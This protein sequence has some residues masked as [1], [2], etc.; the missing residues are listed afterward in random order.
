MATKSTT[1]IATVLGFPEFPGFVSSPP[2][3][4][5]KLTWSGSSEQ[6]TWFGSQPA[7]GGPPYQI[8]GA[9]FDY[10]GS[11]EIDSLGN[12]ISLYTK[13]LFEM[14]SATNDQFVTS[15]VADP[16]G[17]VD[18]Y[19]AP[20]WRGPTGHLK[21]QDPGVPYS[22]VRSTAVGKGDLAILDS[23]HFWGSKPVP[24]TPIPTTNF[25]ASSN[26]D[27][28]CS[29]TGGSQSNGVLLALFEPVPPGTGVPINGATYG[30]LWFFGSVVWI[31]DYTAT[32]SEEYTD[33]EALTHAKTF[34]GNGATAQNFVRTTG[35]TSTFTNVVYTLTLTSLIV[36]QAYVVSVDLW[37]TGTGVTTTKQ[38]G[39]TA[40][41]TTQQITDVIPTP[42][43]QHLVQVRNPR[44]AFAP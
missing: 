19:T 34:V 31:N 11:S 43:P 40:T 25:A 2:K 37:D 23:S 14:C 24:A 22:F 13:D 26:T 20:G 16:Q 29:D 8:A 5:K 28:A 39:I 44:I 36:G 30:L 33:A 41:K 38:Y 12:Y 17:G 4:F 18:P 35:F 1:Q 7:L 3:R 21:C 6:Q 42:P 15:F 27:A 9:R 32:L 10:N